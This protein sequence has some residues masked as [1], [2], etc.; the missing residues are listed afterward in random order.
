MKEV[1]WKI[2]KPLL[3]VLTSFSVFS[4]AFSSSANAQEPVKQDV[5]SNVEREF[6]EIQQKYSI[7]EVD[8][9]RIP[10]EQQILKFDSIEDFEEF[11]KE[12]QMVEDEE[13]VIP[14]HF[15]QQSQ[16]QPFATTDYYSDSAK[17]D[18]YSPFTGWGMT[19][20]VQF[21]Q[22]TFDYKYYYLGKVKRFKAG[23]ITNI[24][25]D[26]YGVSAWSWSQTKAKGTIG[27]T[28]NQASVEIEAD[29]FY[30]LG[31]SI[32]GFTIGAKLPGTITRT[33]YLE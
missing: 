2:K 16:V 17:M 20:L 4:C 15:V 27:G 11:V 25:S 18:W 10:K 1:D 7:E 19:S 23:S 21:K 26:I 30:T 28:L 6:R 32:N 24:S 31:V 29:G 12:L 22:I 5:V 13:V 33:Y 9:N 3:V 14:S 8:I